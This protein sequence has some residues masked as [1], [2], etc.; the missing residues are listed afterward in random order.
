MAITQISAFLENKPGKLAEAITSITEAGINIRALNLA[1]T[2][3]FG[4]LRLIV[5]DVAKAKETLGKEIIIKETPVVAVKM[6]DHSGALKEILD[7]LSGAN[8]NIE[9]VYAFTGAMR[10]SAYVVFRVD[11]I[12]EAESILSQNGI[13]TLKDEDM[14][15]FLSSLK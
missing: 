15:E 11:D 7:V 1:E 8:V 2:K 10:D 3:D 12:A 9:Y 4:I 14:T 5:S 6:E 13:A